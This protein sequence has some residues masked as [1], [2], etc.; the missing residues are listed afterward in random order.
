MQYDVHLYY[1]LGNVLSNIY[2]FLIL[3]DNTSIKDTI[4]KHS[5]QVQR[6]GLIFYY[7]HNFN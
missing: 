4:N 7:F 2:E 1:I 5:P 3:L 6:N